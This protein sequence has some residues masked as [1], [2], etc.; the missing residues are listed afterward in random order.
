M[1][2]STKVEE[3]EHKHGRPVITGQESSRTSQS[4][5]MALVSG[6]GPQHISATR[7]WFGQ[8]SNTPDFRSLSHPHTVR[9][10]FALTF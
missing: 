3:N 5:G 10:K 9:N 6:V 4:G 8:A 1:L 7:L 2:V